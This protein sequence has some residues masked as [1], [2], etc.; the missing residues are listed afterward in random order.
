MATVMVMVRCRC[1]E[2]G[3]RRVA[4]QRSP[5]GEDGQADG[6]IERGFHNVERLTR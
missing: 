1:R 2:G 3:V 5:G 6:Q 4:K